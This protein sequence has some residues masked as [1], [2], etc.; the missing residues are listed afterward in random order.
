MKIKYSNIAALLIALIIANTAL[1][2][3]PRDLVNICEVS[4]SGLPVEKMSKRQ[5]MQHTMCLFYSRGIIEGVGLGAWQAFNFSNKGKS[6]KEIKQQVDRLI[7]CFPDKSV[8]NSNK[9]LAETIIKYIKR[10]PKD[11]SDSSKVP[12]LVWKALLETFPCK[13]G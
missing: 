2:I 5:L 3:T 10:H 13:R 9:L 7:S 1:A 11:M 4:A 12:Y 8:K 6:T